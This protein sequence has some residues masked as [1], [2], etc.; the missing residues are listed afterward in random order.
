GGSAPDML[1]DTTHSPTSLLL[2]ICGVTRWAAIPDAFQVVAGSMR[3]G[4]TCHKQEPRL[5]ITQ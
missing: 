2:Q 5:D 1:N 4:V 3:K